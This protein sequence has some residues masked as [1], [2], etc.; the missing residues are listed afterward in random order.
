MAAASQTA[1]G[2]TGYSGETLVAECI[3]GLAL[4]YED[5]NDHDELRHDP[6]LGLLP[7]KLQARRRACAVLVANRR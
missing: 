4:G 2:R 3:H 5:L 7:G 1:A 6:V